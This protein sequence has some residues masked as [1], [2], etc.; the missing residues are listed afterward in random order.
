[1]AIRAWVIAGGD[2][3][4]YGV[5]HGGLASIREQAPTIV[6]VLWRKRQVLDAAQP[7]HSRRNA[8]AAHPHSRENYASC[9]TGNTTNKSSLTQIFGGFGVWT[10]STSHGAQY[11]DVRVPGR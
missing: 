1:M 11:V 7:N 5:A 3:V 2:T 10:R 8:H 4:S 6:L 9:S